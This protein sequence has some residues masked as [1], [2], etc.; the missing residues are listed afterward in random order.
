M[1]H[2]LLLRHETSEAEIIH[3]IFDFLDAVL[4]TIRSLAKRIILEVQDLESSMKMLDELCNMNRTRV[5][6]LSHTV[7][8]ETCLSGMSEHTYMQVN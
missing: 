7:A 5:V 6:T 1:P 3:N 2:L 8:S 4:D